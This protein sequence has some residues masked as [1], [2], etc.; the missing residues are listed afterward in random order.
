MPVNLLGKPCFYT[1]HQTL[2][3]G[4][5]TESMYFYLTSNSALLMDLVTGVRSLGTNEAQERILKTGMFMREDEAEHRHG[6]LTIM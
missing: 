1:D 4:M 6:N 2:T 5:S 3:F